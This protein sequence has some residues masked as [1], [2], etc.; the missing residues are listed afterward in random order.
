MIYIVG[1]NYTITYK[2]Q[3]NSNFFSMKH[4]NMKMLNIP[5]LKISV[6]IR[7]YLLCLQHMDTYQHAAKQNIQ[8]KV[9]QSHNFM[10]N[11]Q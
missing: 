11:M 5:K 7:I 2:T 8:E 9:Q 10:Q 3:N 4:L 1:H 6:I